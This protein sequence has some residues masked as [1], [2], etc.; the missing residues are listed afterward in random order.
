VRLD[1]TRSTPTKGGSLSYHWEVVA[2][3][4]GSRPTIANPASAKTTFTPDTPGMYRLRVR[5][6]QPGH[7]TSS[8]SVLI[9]IQLASIPPVGLLLH[10]QYAPAS[11]V[12]GVR[13]GDVLIAPAP[14]GPGMTLVLEDRQTLTVVGQPQTSDG[15]PSS[16]GTLTSFIT[17]NKNGTSGDGVIAILSA[18]NGVPCIAAGSVAC[19]FY[20][21]LSSLG[22]QLTSNGQNDGNLQAGKPFSTVSVLPA[23]NPTTWRAT[24]SGTEP[25]PP[26]GTGP[27]D[28]S[29]YVLLS[30][31]GGGPYWFAPDTHLAVDTQKAST[32][33][34]NTMELGQ[35]CDVKTGSSCLTSPPL[36]TCPSA[37]KTGGFHVVVAWA[38]TMA[39]VENRSFTTNSG[40]GADGT[41]GDAAA[42]ADMTALLTKYGAGHQSASV[43]VGEYTVAIQSISA[44]RPQT[45][46][47]EGQWLG[48]AQALAPLGGTPSVLAELGWTSGYTLVGSNALGLPGSDDAH[49]TET[50]GDAPAMDSTARV[51][52]VLAR[53]SRNDLLPRSVVKGAPFQSTQFGMSLFGPPT[54]WPVPCVDGATGPTGCASGTTSAGEQ[55]ALRYVTEVAGPAHDS[56]LKP[57]SDNDGYCYQPSPDTSIRNAYCNTDISAGDW[58]NISSWFCNSGGHVHCQGLDVPSNHSGYAFSAADWKAVSLQL[59][60]ETH[61]VDVLLNRVN[62]ARSATAFMANGGASTKEPLNQFVNAVIK[63]LNVNDSSNTDVQLTWWEELLIVLGVVVLVLGIAAGGSA[64]EAAL[65]EP[66]LLLLVEDGEGNWVP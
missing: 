58:S 2:A 17:N 41:D 12:A 59:S 64:L 36:Q 32:A 21:V 49:A 19:A 10:T 60:V 28:L 40:C 50:S 8:H 54:P 51:A 39:E 25:A 6:S 53:N 30:D 38:G 3:P 24:S 11:G 48:L 5:V 27:A 18:P 13:L 16:V 4:D 57:S 61:Y 37:N 34:T 1:A 20:N 55:A 7:P 22:V 47:V 56:R 65:A 52:G 66:E 23:K 35:P 15:S 29:G 42:I 62:N 33:T 9:P 26:A 43:P 14:T 63:S 46:A 44:P 31:S 45:T